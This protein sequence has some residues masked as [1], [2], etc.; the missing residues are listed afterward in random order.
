MKQSKFCNCQLTRPPG[1]N[2]E[3]MSRQHVEV[4]SRE[5]DPRH[6][7]SRQSRIDLRPCCSVYQQSTA[8]V[9]LA[10]RFPPRLCTD[11][12]YHR[13]AIKTG[14]RSA[15]RVMRSRLPRE[16]REDLWTPPEE[17]FAILRIHRRVFKT[18]DHI[19]TIK[20]M[21]LEGSRLD[22][23]VVWWKHAYLR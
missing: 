11:N 7:S 1:R 12:V 10:T 9:C 6:W 18:N 20:S 4:M 14:F 19:E 15:R 22:A 13:V 16:A 5:G 3:K 17:I 8:T 23:M 2:E 21:V